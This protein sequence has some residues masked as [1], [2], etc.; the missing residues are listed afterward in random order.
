M[1]KTSYSYSTNQ[2]KKHLD[3][4]INLV[5]DNISNYC[6]NPNVDFTRVRKLPIKDLINI[7]LVKES[8][9]ITSEL[10]EY[11]PKVK[12][13]PTASAFI[14]QRNKL[15]SS[16]I[17]SINDTFVNSFD[18]FKSH[19]DYFILAEDGT[20][21]N[22]P[23]PKTV[24]DTQ[25]KMGPNKPYYQFH[26]N[27]LYDCL[28]H[29]F[30][31]LS[32]DSASKK[33]ES[34]ALIKLMNNHNYPQKSIII[35]DRGYENYNLIANF[36]K[37]KQKFLIR[38]KDITSKN[39]I[40]YNLH[41]DNDEFDIVINKIF[42]RKQKY[43]QKGNQGKYTYV[44]SSSSFDC[45][46]KEDEF[47][48]MHFRVIRF[49]LSNDTYECLV[50]NLEENEFSAIEIR[51]LYSFR[52]SE[53]SAFRTLK[54]TIGMLYFTAI[55]RDFIKQEIYAAILL[56]NLGAIIANNIEIEQKERWKYLYKINFSA[57]ITNVR[58]FLKHLI[59]S[60]ELVLRIKKNLVPVRPD[61]KY[62]R[63]MKAQSAKSLNHK[64]A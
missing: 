10:L 59:S 30:Y 41:Q 52:W 40:L 16:A 17:K 6:H 47:F 12:Q 19:K 51:E 55:N 14:Q 46:P 20:D 7:L 54:Y 57:L 50:T 18:N 4:S 2:I 48:E 21:V 5:V 29:V 56:S 32:I 43:F 26:V 45:F 42:T 64:V 33:Q 62:K 24:D 22:I 35:C 13:I 23:K 49:K 63:D 61:R 58:L 1:K 31:D 8:K 38:V 37:N 36:L 53:E 27:A 9:S 44:P 39:G 28:N 60:V 34:N 15:N 11:F 3:N 25:V